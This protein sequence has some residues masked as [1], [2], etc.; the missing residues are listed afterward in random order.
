MSLADLK[1]KQGKRPHKKLSVEEFIEDATAYS[2]GKSVLSNSTKRLGIQHKRKQAVKSTRFKHATFSLSNEC[3]V[4]L[5]QLTQETGINKSKLIRLLVDSVD[6]ESIN[7]LTIDE[8][9]HTCDPLD[10]K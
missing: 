6:A 8:A 1:K 3:I 4:Q 10:K 5:N 2:Q 9:D 7:S